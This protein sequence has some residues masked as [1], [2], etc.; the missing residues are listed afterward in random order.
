MPVSTANNN[1]NNRHSRIT[2]A[3]RVCWTT[4]NNWPPPIPGR[5][6]SMTGKQRPNYLVILVMTSISLPIVDN[7]TS[8][9]KATLSCI[10]PSSGI[11]YSRNL[12]SNMFPAMPRNIKIFVTNW[13]PPSSNLSPLTPIH[14][15]T[16]P[17]WKLWANQS[18][19]IDVIFW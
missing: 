10:F 14:I 9:I 18:N 1:N 3:Y 16:H 5:Y 6:A 8:S 4:A 19:K 2:Q 13:Y 15:H 17:T 11:S 7:I 12:F